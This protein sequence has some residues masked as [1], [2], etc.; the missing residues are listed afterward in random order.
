MKLEELIKAEA[1]RLYKQLKPIYIE[2][3]IK[4]AQDA[5][6]V[7][8][9]VLDYESLYEEA[10]GYYN[11]QGD[12]IVD[13]FA[14]VDAELLHTKLNLAIAQGHSFSQFW[15]NVQHSGMFS[16]DRAKRIYRTE[17]AR[18]YNEGALRQYHKEG[19][20]MV[21]ILLG[22]NP[23]PICSSFAS[24]SPFKTEDLFG[25]LPIH[26]NCACVMVNSSVVPKQ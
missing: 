2:S 11:E 23:C 5:E 14:D 4:G 21:D 1:K 12:W 17:T 10:V 24:A 13:Q 8:K 25:V 20:K 22:P 9:K 7:L 18:A 16:Y 26:P 15:T 6:K 19:V 3:Y